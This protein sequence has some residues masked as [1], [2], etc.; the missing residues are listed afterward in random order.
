MK[1]VTLDYYALL[2]EVRGRDRE[3][4]STDARTTRDLYEELRVRH[5]FPLPWQALQVAVNDEFTVWGHELRAGDRV[6]FIAPV[7][8]G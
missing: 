6:V 3:I 2:R 8:G 5:G 7:A 4:I 1:S